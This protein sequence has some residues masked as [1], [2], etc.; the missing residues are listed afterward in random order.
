MEISK[1]IKC[2]VNDCSYNMNDACNARA[3]TVGDGTS[4]RCDTFCQSMTKGG[5]SG[6]F[7]SVGACKVSSCAFNT[8][9]ECRSPEICVGYKEDEPDCLTFQPK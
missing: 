5:D 7:A 9:L 2:E 8:V 4:P 6:C 3:I 1:V